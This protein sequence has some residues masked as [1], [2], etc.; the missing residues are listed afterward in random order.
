[1]KLALAIPCIAFTALATGAFAESPSELSDLEIA[2][3]AYVADNID[4]RYAHLAL[5]LS[6]SQNVRDFA[7]TMIQHHSSVNE[8]A[9]KLLAELGA[10]PEDNFLS[11]SLVADAQEEIDAMSKLRGAAFDRHYAENELNY[12][13]AVNGLIAGEFLPNIENGQ[14]KALFEEG[15]KLFQAHE[16]SA[17]SLV[18]SLNE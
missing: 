5:A 7:Q 14:V 4:I 16:S 3:V 9:L 10:Q 2:H 8:Q 18:D 1:M 13:R 17:A 11:K 12:H 15:L 6:E